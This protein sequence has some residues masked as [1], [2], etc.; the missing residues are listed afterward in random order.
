[1]EM[2]LI[3]C[4]KLSLMGPKG[5]D[6]FGEEIVVIERFE[7]IGMKCP[8]LFVGQVRLPRSGEEASKERRPSDLVLVLEK[9]LVRTRFMAR[10]CGLVVDEPV[11]HGGEK[12]HSKSGWNALVGTVFGESFDQIRA[13]GV[14]MLVVL[15]AQE[16]MER[17]GMCRTV[18]ACDR[19]PRLPPA[20]LGYGAGWEFLVHQ[21]G[22][23]DM[24][25]PAI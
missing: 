14:A 17:F 2:F 8:P 1:M 16:M 13:E 9:H 6:E 22:K 18:S 11:G 5:L 23:V 15:A 12:G 3:C 21:F 20:F 7:S 10:R 19:E 25:L 4:P 24:P